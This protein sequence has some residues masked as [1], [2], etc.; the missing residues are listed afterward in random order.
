M[1]AQSMFGGT[2]PKDAATAVKQKGN[3]G[4]TGGGGVDIV[5]KT[6]V[7]QVGTHS[8]GGAN[9]HVLANHHTSVK[10]PNLPGKEDNRTSW[11]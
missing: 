5:R 7:K 10:R 2:S 3:S 4:T 9:A 11:K 1:K 8:S 6:G